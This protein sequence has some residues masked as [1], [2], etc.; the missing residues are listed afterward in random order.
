[1][2]LVKI[3]YIFCL[4]VVFTGFK[5]KDVWGVTGHRATGEIAE[6]HLSKRAKRKIKKLLKGEGLA[7]VSTYAD[8]IK[9]DEKYNKF[10]SWHYVNMP[11]DGNYNTAIKNSKGDLVT[12]IEHCVIVL[13]DEKSSIEEK[14]FYL[15]MLVHFLGDLHQPM[16]V[17]QKEDKGGNTIQ[18]EWFNKGT[19]LHRVWD[20]DILSNWGMS[21]LELAMNTKELSEEEIKEIEKG[22]VID[23]LQ[24]THKLTKKVYKSVKKGENLQY[25]YSYDYMPVVREQLQKGGI[26]LAKLLNDIFS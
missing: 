10:Y 23:W 1:M 24:D 3:F 6:K 18:L 12:G 19:N 14:Q 26:R 9:S 22:T 8:G 17:G 25:K 21:Y 4:F 11:L 2:K 16:H 13:K 7:F 15:K 20:T 5:S